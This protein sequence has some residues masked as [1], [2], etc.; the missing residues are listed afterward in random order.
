MCWS[1]VWYCGLNTRQW[2]KFCHEELPQCPCD[3]LVPE[4]LAGCGVHTLPL[5]SPATITP[6]EHSTQTGTSVIPSWCDACNTSVEPHVDGTCPASQ[7]VILTNHLQYRP[8]QRNPGASTDVQHFDSERSDQSCV[9][10]EPEG[11]GSMLFCPCILC[12]TRPCSLCDSSSRAS[13]SLPSLSCF[14]CEHMLHR[15]LWHGICKLEQSL[16]TPATVFL[17]STAQCLPA[18]LSCSIHS[19]ARA[20]VC[21]LLHS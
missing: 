18:A 17:C 21:M 15:L 5:P 14:S 1:E 13:P 2:S 16:R 6:A 3:Q 4:R 11:P 19:P 8:Q 12:I 9:Q 7:C 10:T 20:P